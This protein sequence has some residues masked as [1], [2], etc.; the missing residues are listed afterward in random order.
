MYE[1]TLTESINLPTMS[2][3]VA[4]AFPNELLAKQVYQ[5]LSLDS[6]TGNS[7]FSPRCSGVKLGSFPLYHVIVGWGFP[8]TAQ[9]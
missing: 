3:T 9:G 2:S 8:S 4:V 7:K 1:F 6:D 5:P